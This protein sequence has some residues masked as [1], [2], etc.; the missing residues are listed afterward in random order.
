[1]AQDDTTATPRLTLATAGEMPFLPDSVPLRLTFSNPHDAPILILDRFAPV[2]VFFSFDIARRDGTPV[3]VPGSGKID[4]GPMPPD[5]RQLETHDSHSV[6]I[7]LGRLVTA[8]LQAGDYSVSAT[9][10]NQYG[11]RCFHGA[12]HSNSIT[13]E[14]RDRLEV[15]R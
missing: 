7:D 10:H 13:I 1:M 4:F 5:C 8:P 3:L 2:P 15:G 12:V 6:E 9:Y 14:I 11:D